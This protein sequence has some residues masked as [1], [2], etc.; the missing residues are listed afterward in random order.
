MEQR[1]SIVTLGTHDLAR[2][3]AFWEA[4]GLERKVK[5]YEGVAFF[6]LN[7]LML[8]LWRTSHWGYRLLFL[9]LALLLLFLR[10]DARREQRQKGRKKDFL[11]KSHEFR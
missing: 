1:I 3:S 7:G 9:G 10:P 4:M 5:Q 11:H 8:G 6:Q 2:A